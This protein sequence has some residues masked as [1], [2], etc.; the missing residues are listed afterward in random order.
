MSVR[1]VN[2]WENCDGLARLLLWEEWEGG[3]VE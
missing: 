2:G 1:N 3:G